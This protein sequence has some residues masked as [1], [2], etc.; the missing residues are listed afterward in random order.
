MTGKSSVGQCIARSAIRVTVIVVLSV[1]VGAGWV[2]W[3]FPKL[4]WLPDANS[5]LDNA[6]TKASASITAEQVYVLVQAGMDGSQQVAL[7]DA[8]PHDKFLEGHIAA[9]TILNIHG[10]E[11]YEYDMT[12]LELIRDCKVVVYCTSSTC[13]LA[14]LVY[15]M[16]VNEN[17]FEDVSIYHDGWE[18]WLETEYETESGP[19]KYLGG[20]LPGAE[21]E[22]GGDYTDDSDP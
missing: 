5:V 4:H 22:F 20:P 9:M 19:E 10:D 12:Y 13:H 16:L 2:R 3:R 21:D 6:E 1:S 18:G 8:R 7:I 11:R 14:G 15:N 17:G